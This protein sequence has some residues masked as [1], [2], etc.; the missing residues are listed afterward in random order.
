MFSP[1]VSWLLPGDVYAQEDPN[2]RAYVL[3]V[4][5]LGS[6]LLSVAGFCTVLGEEIVLK[7]GYRHGVGLPIVGSVLLI[8]TGLYLLSR[9]RLAYVAA[10]LFLVLYYAVAT[11]CLYRWGVYLS[12]GLMLYTLIIVMA[13]ILM[14]TPEAITVTVLNSVTLLVLTRLQV[15]HRIHPNLYWITG[16][17]GADIVDVIVLFGIIFAVSWLSNHEIAK[18]LRRALH[19]ERLLKEERDA[20]EIKV[21]ERTAELK[22]IQVEKLSQLSRFAEVGKQTSTIL[23]DLVNP[24]TSVSLNLELL[25]EDVSTAPLVVQAREGIKRM[26]S[27]IELA[28]KQIHSQREV[29]IFAV[30]D[31]LRQILKM[32]EARSKQAKVALEVQ[33]EAEMYLHGNPIKFHQLMN[34]LI[35]NGIDAY[36]GLSPTKERTVRIILQ[37]T[38]NLAQIM[39]QDHGKGISTDQRQRIFEPF[40]TTKQQPHNAGL[41]LSICKDIVEEE[42]GGTIALQSV[43]G[44]STTFTIQI[45]LR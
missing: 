37:Q 29:Q 9:T 32:L 7:S 25:S 24:L 8:F 30:T 20:L 26:E 18:S 11:Y 23:H 10:Y 4:L 38:N 15:L 36:E 2:R 44:R 45:P 34:N 14:G 43:P 41:G 31:E 17:Y 21:E 3:Q 35:A 12:M 42:F 19:S 40:F 16:A 5:L 27:F 39:V 22:A 28:Q 6:V 1:F 13:G 33:K